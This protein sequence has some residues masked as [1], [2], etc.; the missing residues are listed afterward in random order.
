MSNDKKEGLNLLENAYSLSSA[1]DNSNYYDA[2]ASTYDRDFADGL[3][4]VIPRAI[5]D[6]FNTL[7]SESDYPIADIGCGTGLVAL[8]LGI[9]KT[10]IDGLDISRKMLEAAKTIL[11]LTCWLSYSI[12]ADQMR[13]SLSVLMQN[14]IRKC[15]S[16][17]HWK[18]YLREIK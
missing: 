4:Y 12:S 8:E 18:I 10:Q 14:T 6:V 15:P 9:E 3:G 1:V 16:L 5:A 13:Y 7:A 11:V 17:W 2:F